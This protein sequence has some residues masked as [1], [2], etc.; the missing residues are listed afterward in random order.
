MN[1]KNSLFYSFL[2]IATIILSMQSCHKEENPAESVAEK[3]L[4]CMY[5]YD[6]DNASSLSTAC[7]QKW[8]TFQASNVTQEELDI[9]SCIG[10]FSKIISTSSEAINDSITK[11][12]CKVD[13]V[14]VKSLQTDSIYFTTIPTTVNVVKR[15]NRWLVKM[16]DP[17]QS[18]K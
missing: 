1:N 11:V 14:A 18:E 3:F 15:E 13:N 6:F 7:S 9:K 2:A 12:T 17:L 10:T 16:E 4:T 8:I 5:N